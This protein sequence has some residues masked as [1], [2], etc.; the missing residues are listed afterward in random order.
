LPGSG[1]YDRRLSLP[2]FRT[3]DLPPMKTA[4]DLHL[5][6]RASLLDLSAAASDGDCHRVP[7]ATRPQ[8]RPEVDLGTFA[9]SL[10]SSAYFSGHESMIDG[11]ALS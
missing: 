6:S 10:V 5:R 3:L 7:V 11:N 4:L 8:I 9:R 2:R 1:L